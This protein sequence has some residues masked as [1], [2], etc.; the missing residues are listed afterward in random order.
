MDKYFIVKQDSQLY[1]DY[2]TYIEDKKKINKLFKQLAE[3]HGIETKEYYPSKNLGI[4]GT[5]ND[6]IKFANQLKKDSTFFK[7]KSEINKE[8][9]EFTK[10]IKNWNKPSPG[11]YLQK[12]LLGRYNTRLFSI[13]GILYCSIEADA[14]FETEAWMQEMKA[15]E[16]FKTIEDYEESEG[17]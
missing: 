17:K 10:E 1:V 12:S 4:V 16:F 14:E 3:K 2:F 15:S 5:K 7:L 11:W 8:W 9:S 13:D 6:L